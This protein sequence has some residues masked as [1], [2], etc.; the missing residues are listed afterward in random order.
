MRSRI[1]IQIFIEV[2]SWIRIR[3]RIK[4]MWIRNPAVAMLFSLERSKN[5]QQIKETKAREMVEDY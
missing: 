2:T 3:I 5:R 1:R 4:L